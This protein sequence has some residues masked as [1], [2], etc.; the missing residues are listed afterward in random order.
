[1]NFER[2]NLEKK[3][4]KA[5]HYTAKNL[6][7]SGHNSKPVL[8]HSFKVSELLSRYGYKEEIVI[9]AALHDLIE[10]TDVTYEMLVNDFGKEIADL[11]LAVSFDPKVEDKLVQA[12]LMFENAKNYGKDA[13]LIKC[14]DL[15]DNIQFVQFVDDKQK[16]IEL[17]K[18]YDLFIKIAKDLIGEEEIF[19]LL[20]DKFEFY[21]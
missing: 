14:S 2:M 8:F 19:K 1:M 17:F 15:I 13:L 11:V 7:K 9:A 3:L 16:R 12:K 21:R 6:D 5:L 10:D 4:D 20:Q 18:K